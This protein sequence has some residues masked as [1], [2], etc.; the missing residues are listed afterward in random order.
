MLWVP[1]QYLLIIWACWATSK[2]DFTTA[3]LIGIIAS[4]GINAG[5]MGINIAHELIHKNTWIEKTLGKILLT[6]V[7]YG[8][9]FIEHIY[10]HHDR[11]S[12]P[13]DPATSRKNETFYSFW[14][15]CVW[16][17]IK[18]SIELEGKRLEKEDGIKTFWHYKNILFQLTGG[19]LLF[20][21]LM[22]HFFGAKGLKVFFGQ[23]LVAFSL[24][25]VINYIEH[26]GLQRKKLEPDG[27]G[28]ERYQRVDHIHS[29]NADTRTTNLLLFKLQRHS[30]HH[31]FAQRRYQIL[32]SFPESPQMPT[33][34]AGMLTIALCP[35]LWF[36]IMNPR[37]EAFQSE[38]NLPKPT[39]QESSQ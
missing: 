13:N 9:W 17:T 37:L 24:L 35:P 20:A 21:S 38:K 36:R 15:R 12:T 28:K 5:V 34:Y 31:A 19:S 27:S 26:Y 29:W 10:G 8:H 23:S 4:T 30:D 22:F 3:Q 7:C 14:P 33:G 11:V 18:S 1:L 39:N 25:E 16:G 6:S 2:Y 32:R